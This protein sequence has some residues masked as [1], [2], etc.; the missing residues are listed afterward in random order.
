MQVMLD[1]EVVENSGFSLKLA[2]PTGTSLLVEGK[3]LE[4]PEGTEQVL[5]FHPRPFQMER[6]S[7]VIASCLQGG[8][9]KM[10]RRW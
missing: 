10:N 1:K 8:D 4:S 3:L 6:I 9:K 2:T 7:L 5:H